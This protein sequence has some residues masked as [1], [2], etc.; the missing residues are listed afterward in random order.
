MKRQLTEAA[1]VAKL[2]KAELKKHGIK[3]TAKSKNYSMG[4]SARISVTDQPP[5]IMDK[6]KE[7]TNKFQYGHFNG[8]EDI[9]EYSNRQEDIPQTK[10]LF[11]DNVYTKELCQLAWDSFR[12]IE[13]CFADYPDNYEDAKEHDYLQPGFNELGRKMHQYLNGANLYAGPQFCYFQK[14]RLAA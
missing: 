6:I 2:I 1:Q 10:Y 9:Y 4:D 7:F 13:T 3:C 5:W 12:K 11:I 8:M 14:E